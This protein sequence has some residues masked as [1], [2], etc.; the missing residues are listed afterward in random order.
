M[1]VPILVLSFTLISFGAASPQPREAAAE[2]PSVF[3]Q[4]AFVPAIDPPDRSLASDFHEAGGE[5][6]ARLAAASG[7]DSVSAMA[8]AAATGPAGPDA[9]HD[10]L[11]ATS[12]P[13]WNPAHPVLRRRL[14]EYAVLLPGRIVSLPLSAVGRIADY[15]LTFVEQRDIPQRV[16]YVTK[17]L[18]QR[19]GLL[20]KPA[21]LGDRTGL[22]GTFDARTKFLKVGYA[23]FLRVT[24]SASTLHYHETLLRMSGA[25]ASFEYG[26]AW[27]PQDQFFGRGMQTAEGPAANYATETEWARATLDIAWNRREESRDLRT[28][29]QL[30]GGPRAIVTRR[31]REQ[32]RP[33]IE[34]L[35]PGAVASTLDQTFEQLVYGVRFSSDWR[36][37]TPHWWEGWRVLLQSE[38]FDRAISTLAIHT[39]SRTGAQFTRTTVELEG[40]TSF[41]RDPRTLR[42][43]GRIVDLGPTSGAERMAVA[44]LS[45]LGGRDGLRGFQPGRFHDNDL[46]LARLTYL[47]PLVRRFEMDM[48]VESGAVFPDLWRTS[49][50]DRLEQSAGIALRGRSDK[51]PMAAV[52]LDVSRE[53]VRVRFV[54]G[55]PDL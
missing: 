21:S 12:D 34:S 39:A 2:I 53:S 25:P 46:M 54:F 36:L 23:E 40:A 28:H 14:W 9:R 51:H 27:R 11:D 49:R 37:G 35:F 45:A 31:G 38:R 10:D 18:P 41:G 52:G 47:F 24:H 33:S 8:L 30:F 32:N 16:A 26:Y 5:P 7:A 4:P 19:T 17:A 55:N 6:A 1:R 15:S 29:L 50:F 42:L 44:D 13:P 22:G 48:H 3:E 20:I 43:V